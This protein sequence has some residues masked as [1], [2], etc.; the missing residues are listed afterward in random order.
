MSRIQVKI[1][2]TVVEVAISRYMEDNH[3]TRK[4][5]LDLLKKALTSE[6]PIIRERAMIVIKEILL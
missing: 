4:Y 6:N 1:T 3:V 2:K 5:C